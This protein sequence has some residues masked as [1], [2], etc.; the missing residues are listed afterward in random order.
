ML[1][2]GI[3]GG[4][5]SGKTHVCKLLETIGISV[6][7]SD[8]VG[9]DLTNNNLT[10][11]NKM[12]ELLGDEAYKNDLLNSKYVASKVFD[13]KTLLQ[14]INSIIHPAVFLAFEEWCKSHAD[15]KVVVA[16]SAVLFESGFNKYMDKTIVVTAPLQLRISRIMNRDKMTYPEVEARINNQLSDDERE[17]KADYIIKND[18]VEYL[19][20]QIFS[21]LKEIDY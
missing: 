16:E 11:K 4:I 15:E 17:A 18:G 1:K 21:L 6:F 20:S 7:Y 19:P 2:I 14:K 12:I 10:I 3:T 5:G 9:K 8:M 13:D